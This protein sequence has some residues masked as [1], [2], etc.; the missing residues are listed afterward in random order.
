MKLSVKLA[1]LLG[2]GVFILTALPGFYQQVRPVSFTSMLTEAVQSVSILE[3]LGFSLGGALVAGWIGYTIG[4]ILSKP[5]GGMA[6]PRTAAPELRTGGRSDRPV[7]G[8][9]TFLDDLSSEAPVPVAPSPLEPSPLKPSS[10][11]EEA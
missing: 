2:S 11:E 10:P 8:E 3:K 7:T 4:D 1:G 5:K 6:R 9:E